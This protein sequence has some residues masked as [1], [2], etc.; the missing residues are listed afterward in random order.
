MIHQII[1]IIFS[2]KSQSIYA[3]LLLWGEFFNDDR[4]LTSCLRDPKLHQYKEQHFKI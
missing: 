3:T 4:K 1:S 2:L